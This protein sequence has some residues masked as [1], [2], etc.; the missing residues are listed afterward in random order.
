MS[1]TTPTNKPTITQLQANQLA[2]L[3]G[4]RAEQAAKTQG[5]SSHDAEILL[6]AA[7]GGFT[8]AGMAFPPIHG[9]FMLLLGKVEE[10]ATARPL[11][12]SEMGNLAAL[13]F[14]LKEPELAWSMIKDSEAAGL[15]EETVTEFSMRFTF[16]Q[17]TALMRWVGKEMA[18]MKDSGDSAGK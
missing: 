6:D 12:G 14:I 4:A 17:M 18:R 9:G 2:F 7:S 1:D 10:L 8:V 16:A 11:L 3:A 15:F 5:I 13:A